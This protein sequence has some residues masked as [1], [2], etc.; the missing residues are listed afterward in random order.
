[1][2]DG[3]QRVVVFAVAVAVAEVLHNLK[4]DRGQ[5]RGHVLLQNRRIDLLLRHWRLMP[6]P[7]AHNRHSQHL[8]SA[9]ATASCLA[10]KHRQREGSRQ[11]EVDV[12][13]GVEGD[14]YGREKLSASRLGPNASTRAGRSRPAPINTEDL[15][16]RTQ[17]SSQALPGWGRKGTPTL[18][19]Q[20]RPWV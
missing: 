20:R 4:L 3:C 2:E 6:H 10:T 19:Q 8:E 11:D 1:M 17:A 13:C 15:P 7:H 5:V 16:S 12:C 9:P 18:L 14:D